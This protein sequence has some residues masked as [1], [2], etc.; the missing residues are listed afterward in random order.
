M[1]QVFKA[2]HRRMDRIVALKVIRTDRLDQRRTPSSASSREIRRRP[3][4][5]TR[6]SSCAYDADQVGG[7]HFLVM[8]YVEG[9][10]L[11]RWSK[12]SGPLPV[13]EAC[14]YIRQAALGLQ[15]AHERGLVHRDIKPANLLLTADDG[16][17]VKILDMGLARLRTRRRRRTR[18]PRLTQDGTVMGTPDYIAPEQALDAHARRHPR[19]PLQPG[20][21]AL[22][23]AD[24]PGAVPRRHA[25]RE[26]AAT[27]AGGTRRD[28]TALP[29]HA[30]P[31]WRGWSAA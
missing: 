31:A 27:P 23:P 9:T 26:A 5:R 25:H 8:E 2:R 20:L 19:R 13:G 12:S 18:R 14:D 15:H 4:C 11:G 3:S 22:L 10:D 6:T 30:R 29:R 28:R 16:T 1:G 7:S 24:R 17:C 21:H